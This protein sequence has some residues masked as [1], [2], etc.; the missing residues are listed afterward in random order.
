M[1]YVIDNWM[2]RKRGCEFAYSKKQQY[3]IIRGMCMLTDGENGET[4]AKR[5]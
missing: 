1:E 4:G 3:A 5:G 2:T